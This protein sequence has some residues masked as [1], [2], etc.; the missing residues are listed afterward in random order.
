VLGRHCC[1]PFRLAVVSLQGWLQ[2]SLWHS[3]F[4]GAL[5]AGDGSRSAVLRCQ[6]AKKRF[7]LWPTDV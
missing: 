7:D 2:D 5:R 3:V 6:A 1:E 4:L